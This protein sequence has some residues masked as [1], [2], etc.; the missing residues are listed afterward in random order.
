MIKKKI[1]VKNQW[2]IA[3][4]MKRI[5]SMSSFIDKVM[6]TYKN[7][8]LLSP[9][10]K[11]IFTAKTFHNLNIIRSDLSSILL[12]EYSGAVYYF[13]PHP[14]HVLGDNASEIGD[15]Q[16]FTKANNHI[17][18]L[19]GNKT[20]LDIY[21]ASQLA[22]CGCIVDFELTH[23]FSSNQMIGIIG[24]YMYTVTIA[25]E[26]S[27]YFDM[28]FNNIQDIKNFNVQLFQKIFHMKWICTLEVVRDKKLAEQK[29]HSIAKYF[30]NRH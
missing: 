21:G 10:E 19:F 15:I 25:H 14:Y 3:L 9:W 18:Y 12:A 24:E 16:K 7:E 28:F 5:W 11:K 22:D 8:R 1:L 30:E 6:T 13:D 26:I 23:N 2:V 17:Y 29:A 27:E 4:N 20:S